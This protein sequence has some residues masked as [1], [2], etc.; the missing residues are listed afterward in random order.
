M[1]PN[2]F[3]ELNHF[4]VPIVI[5]SCLDR[6]LGRDSAARNHVTIRFLKEEHHDERMKSLTAK[7]V[8]PN[9]EV[10]MWR[11]ADAFTRATDAIRRVGPSVFSPFAMLCRGITRQRLL[12]YEAPGR[13]GCQ[14]D[15]DYRRRRHD[16]RHGLRMDWGRHSR[17]RR[18]SRTQTARVCLRRARSSDLGGRAVRPEAGEREWGPTFAQREMLQLD[19]GAST[20]RTVSVARSRRPSSPPRR[21]VCKPRPAWPRE[22]CPALACRQLH[23]HVRQGSVGPEPRNQTIKTV[24][25]GEHIFRRRSRIIVTADAAI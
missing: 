1:N 8:L 16:D 17:W 25:A 5:L 7:F 20:V 15:V 14:P 21:Q 9:I 3:S 22:V 23:Q 12:Q 11:F 6:V 13:P 19:G 10:C 2:P 4:T 18:S 24:A